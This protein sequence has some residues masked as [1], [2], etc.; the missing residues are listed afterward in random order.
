MCITTMNHKQ[1]ILSKETFARMKAKNL[2]QN[3]VRFLKSDWK[4][5]L[6]MKDFSLIR[7]QKSREIQF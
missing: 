2:N 6:K 7:S 4:T 1:F 5:G 3:L